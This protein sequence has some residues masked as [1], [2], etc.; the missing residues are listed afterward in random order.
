VP[1][2]TDQGSPPGEHESRP[3]S[4]KA[5]LLQSL[6]QAHELDHGILDALGIKHPHIPILSVI[7]MLGHLRDK[8]ADDSEKRDV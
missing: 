1:E 7:E 4:R 8:H 3:Q 2:T 5:S 6:K